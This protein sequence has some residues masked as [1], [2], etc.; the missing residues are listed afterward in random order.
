MHRIAIRL[1]SRCAVRSFES[2][3]V[4][5]NPQCELGFLTDTRRMNVALTRA[6]RS[7]TVFGDSSTLANHEFYLRLLEYFENQEAYGNVWELGE[8][9]T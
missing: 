9:A 7:L 4:R 1:A 5:S 2:S 8:A 6:R 3:L